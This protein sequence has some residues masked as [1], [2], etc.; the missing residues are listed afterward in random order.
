MVNGRIYKIRCARC[1]KP[2]YH[3]MDDEMYASYYS[4]TYFPICLECQ[5]LEEQGFSVWYKY[6]GKIRNGRGRAN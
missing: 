3:W 5:V 1:G 2:Y 4:H 6:W